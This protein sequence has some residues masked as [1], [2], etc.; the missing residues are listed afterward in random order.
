LGGFIIL[1]CHARESG[2]PTFCPTTVARS[3]IPWVL[4]RSATPD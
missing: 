1:P 2:H 4:K 3:W